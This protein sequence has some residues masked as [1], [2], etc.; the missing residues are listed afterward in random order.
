[1]EADILRHT[2][3]KPKLKPQLI[4]G[5]AQITD[6]D[7]TNVCVK[8]GQHHWSADTPIGSVLTN[9]RQQFGFVRYLRRRVRRQMHD[10]TVEL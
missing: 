8:S 4:P 2:A 7:L 3:H 5:R 9:C 10:Q 6:V 1:M